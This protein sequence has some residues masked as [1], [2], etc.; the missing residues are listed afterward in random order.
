MNTE[1][2]C[3]MNPP[4]QS[5]MLVA[6][7]RTRTSPSVRS[8]LAGPPSGF[9]PRRTRLMVGSGNIE[10]WVVCARFMVAMSGTAEGRM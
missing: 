9:Q 10:K 4:A 8:C 3:G 2:P 5:R 7:L 6:T 1:L